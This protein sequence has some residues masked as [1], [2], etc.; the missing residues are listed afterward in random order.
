MADLQIQENTP[1]IDEFM[2]FDSG[3]SF[4]FFAG[5]IKRWLL[6]GAD[7]VLMSRKSCIPL[8]QLD[9]E[10][11]EV[12]N[13]S[14]S[15]KNDKKVSLKSEKSTLQL[16]SKQVHGISECYIDDYVDVSEVVNSPSGGYQ[17]FPLNI[18][19]F[20][21]AIIL[22]MVGFQIN[23]FLGFFMFPIR[24][25]YFTV[26]LMMFPF[27]TVARIRNYIIKMF[28]GMWVGFYTSLT[29]FMYKKIKAQ[30]ALMHLAIRFTWAIFWAIYVCFL[31]VGLLVSGFIVGGL[32]MRRL[33]EEPIQTTQPLNF[34]YTRASPVAFMP[35]MSSNGVAQSSGMISKESMQA[36]GEAG[37]RAIP[38][39]HKL[40]LKVSLSLPESEYNRK[41][42]IFQVKVEFLSTTGKVTASS[43]YPSMLKFKSQSVRFAETMFKTIPLVAGFQSESQILDV[44]FSDFTE[45][46]EPTACLRVILE[47]R[48]E[49]QPGAGIPEIYSAS[50]SVKSELPQ[51][52]KIV[53]CWRRTIFV[54][55]SFMTFLMELAVILIFCRPLILLHRRKGKSLVFKSDEENI[56]PNKISW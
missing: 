7:K 26:M 51:L 48:A 36:V 20:L 55:I 28:L 53:W 27:Q 42:G 39:N 10:P 40:Q 6:H 56:K 13:K 46:I 3:S 24:L 41:L 37:K 25:S 50:L 54:W 15:H 14:F 2:S 5:L 45:G 52:R 8:L 16:S 18:I 17:E 32:T 22:K 35:I 1:D 33:V 31:L 47:Q 34:D 4:R 49:H 29:S 43:S 11:F 21:A 23:L 38:Y 9:S 44:K 30:K 12:Y 19:I